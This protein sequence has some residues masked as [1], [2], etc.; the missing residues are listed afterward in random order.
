MEGF[1]D[2]RINLRLAERGFQIIGYKEYLELEGVLFTHIPMKGGQPVGGQYALQ[3]AFEITPKALVFAHLHRYEFLH[4]RRLKEDKIPI[5]CA[6]C[7]FDEEYEEDF[8]KGCPNP[9]WRGVVLLDIY[10]TGQFDAA[11]ICLDKLKGGI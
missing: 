9:Y 1:V 4:G 5:L 7:F 10:K 11:Q 8:L 6:G 2:P 3:R